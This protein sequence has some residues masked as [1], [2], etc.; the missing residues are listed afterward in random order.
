[1]LQVVPVTHLL[2]CFLR[3]PLGSSLSG[4]VRP[5]TGRFPRVVLFI[6]VGEG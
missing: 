2:L 4:A 3:N 6:Y 5:L 1:M